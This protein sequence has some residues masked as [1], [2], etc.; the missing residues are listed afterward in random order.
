MGFF[1]RLGRIMV[2]QVRRTIHEWN[3]NS[4]RYL[5]FFVQGS[6]PQQQG[7]VKNHMPNNQIQIFYDP[8]QKKIRYSYRN[9]P[10][11]EWEDLHPSAALSKTKFQA[12]A[13]QT[14]A[15]DIVS[16]LLKDYCS[17]NSCLDLC[18]CGT[19]SDWE[20]LKTVVHAVDTEHKIRCCGSAGQ[21]ASAEEVFPKIQEL[22]TTLTNEFD[23]NPEPS[24]REP[25]DQY[26]EVVRPE[27]V[28]C[29]VGTYSSGK[30][31][32]INALIGEEILPTAEDPLTATIFK[33]KSMR[34][35]TW[36]DTVL[37][38]QYKGKDT[39]IHFGENGYVFENLNALENFDLKH[40][41]D[42]MLEAR[43]V[44]LGPAYIY[45]ILSVL[46]EF[47]SKNP[48][49]VSSQI[50]VQTPFYH[51]SLPLDTFQFVIYD[52]P[53]SDS[54]SNEKH[55]QV[56]QQ[57]LKSQTN[58]LPLL[59]TTRD[60]LDATSVANLVEYIDK[61][62]ALDKSN[63]LIVVN[64]ADTNTSSAL[65]DLRQKAGNLA[66]LK[67]AENRTFVVSSIVGLGAKKDGREVG[68]TENT[69]ELFE[70]AKAKFMAEDPSCKKLFAYDLLSP[71]RHEQIRKAGEAANNTGSEQQ[72][73]FHNSGLWAVE[74]EIALFA[75][76]YALYHK[77]QQAQSYLF[78]AIQR[79]SEIQRDKETQQ[80][81][82][83]A[84]LQKEL[85]DGKKALIDQLK[86]GSNDW[87]K[88]KFTHT[89]KEQLKICTRC[90]QFEF[91][92]DVILQARWQELKKGRN[93]FAARKLLNE[94]AKK[95]VHNRFT[96]CQ[97]QLKKF[98]DSFWP[99]A[100]TTYKERC[101][102]IVLAS[103][104]L[105]KEEKSLMEHDILSLKEPHIQEPA[106]EFRENQFD[107]HSLLFGL[108]R[109]TRP[110]W[111]ECATSMQEDL[112]S[113]IT[114]YNSDYLDNIRKGIRKWDRR[115]Q[116]DLISK[117]TQFNSQLHSL[118]I[119]FERCNQ[120]LRVLQSTQEKLTASAQELKSYFS[121]NEEE[122][123][124]P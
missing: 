79:L 123:E 59:I 41:I 83:R 10:D 109:W 82:R 105:T 40:C 44:P 6:Y 42:T 84:D 108:F 72:R 3:Y 94:W 64:K 106:F 63:I 17:G 25:L 35:G 73:L 53:G 11:S 113:K 78:S 20:D 46:N 38:F 45:E 58:A 51:S 31:S 26:L 77:C 118:S 93:S 28:L 98:T 120:E 80:E 88:E 71:E 56:L 124:E 121:L 90:T 5:V 99:S 95:E 2:H 117:L 34:S 86:K 29:V 57:S 122:T 116:D 85:S 16:E 103:K 13:L 96:N 101:L 68:C 50:E 21:L 61:I 54:E 7:S 60:R 75:R 111:K 15:V 9:N 89:S 104:D 52:T 97:R 114:C 27:V 69:R 70:E 43:K 19:A 8:Y 39:A 81:S 37:R 107:T 12:G 4:H 24:V 65:R 92:L 87:Q 36:Q 115:F 110:R 62:P 74:N 55:L 32:F 76:K 30:S 33:V 66:A 119:D 48:D 91:S 102:E 22:F 18:F 47:S 1:H 100:I 23:R 49:V 67:N 112:K 14:K